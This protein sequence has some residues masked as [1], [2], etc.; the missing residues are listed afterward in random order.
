MSHAMQCYPCRG[1]KR[2]PRHGMDIW[3]EASWAEC[4]HSQQRTSTKRP[5]CCSAWLVIVSYGSWV[6]GAIWIKPINL[7][8]T[9]KLFQ[10]IVSQ[11]PFDE[12]APL[13]VTN[14]NAEEIVSGVLRLLDVKH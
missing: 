3:H 5:G 1:L 8:A 9:S 12:I 11:W 13:D 10:G 7:A 4:V 6:F 2:V 14:R